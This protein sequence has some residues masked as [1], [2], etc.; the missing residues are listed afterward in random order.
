MALLITFCTCHIFALDFTDVLLMSAPTPVAYDVGIH[1]IAG[2][3]RR[4]CLLCSLLL[5]TEHA[6][7]RL[8][9]HLLL[10]NLVLDFFHGSR[11]ELN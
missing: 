1:L 6:A 7:V 2:V 3:P 10:V 8:H 11:F 5:L 4:P 9:S